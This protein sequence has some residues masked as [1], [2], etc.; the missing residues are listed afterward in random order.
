MQYKNKGEAIGTHLRNK[1]L[2]I[3]DKN[4]YKNTLL[5]FFLVILLYNRNMANS[6]LLASRIFI[7][8]YQINRIGIL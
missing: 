6:F 5:F 1:I 4:V 7:N 2:R 3:K 8:M